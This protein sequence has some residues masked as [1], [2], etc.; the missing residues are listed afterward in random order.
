MRRQSTFAQDRRK[1]WY[2]EDDLTIATSIGDCLLFS[3]IKYGMFLAFPLY[4]AMLVMGFIH[5]NDCP[6]NSRIPWYLIFGGTYVTMYDVSL[7]VFS[8][9]ALPI[10]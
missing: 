6:I 10:I 9:N 8:S 3:L 5:R 1:E 7:F 4:V 2:H